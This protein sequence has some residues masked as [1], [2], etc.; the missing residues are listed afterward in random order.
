MLVAANQGAVLRVGILRTSSIGDVVLAS[1]CLTLL[2]EIDLPVEV[3][4]LG[5]NPALQLLRDAYPGLPVVEVTKDPSI[6]ELVQ[7][8]Q[9]TAFL[10]DLQGNWRSRLLARAFKKVY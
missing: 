2:S 10:L 3:L 5:R 9:G 7:Q 8:L 1:A 6:P 4:W